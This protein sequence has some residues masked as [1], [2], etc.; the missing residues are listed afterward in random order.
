M[1]VCIYG[2]GAVG[3]NIAVRLL[4]GGAAVVSVVA[5]SAGVATPI[6]DVIVAL[7]RGLDRTL[8]AA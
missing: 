4:A 2:A 6:L 8:Q 3:S 1:K 5:R 7:A